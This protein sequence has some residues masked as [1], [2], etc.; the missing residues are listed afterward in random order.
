MDPCFKKRVGGD[1][2][3]NLVLLRGLSNK[4]EFFKGEGFQKN[5]QKKTHHIQFPFY[6]GLLRL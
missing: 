5:F 3:D 4:F 2:K 1:P 6:Q